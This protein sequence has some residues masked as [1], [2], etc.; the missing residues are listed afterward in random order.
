MW[1]DPPSISSA[2]EIS[3]PGQSNGSSSD[4]GL[5]PI[6]SESQEKKQLSFIYQPGIGLYDQKKINLDQ[7]FRLI[8]STADVDERIQ[9]TIAFDV[10]LIVERLLL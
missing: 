1:C 4:D 5:Q 3:Q 7:D 2:A 6:P 9:V 8:S 10:I